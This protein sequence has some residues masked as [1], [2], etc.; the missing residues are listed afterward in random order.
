MKSFETMPIFSCHGHG[1]PW[2]THDISG[3]QIHE[4]MVYGSKKHSGTWGLF[5]VFVHR[6]MGEN[7]R[8]SLPSLEQFVGLQNSFHMQK[9]ST[10]QFPK[11][12]L[13]K[14]SNDH[15]AG[16]FQKVKL[17]FQHGFN[18]STSDTTGGFF[19][20]PGTLPQYRGVVL[21]LLWFCFIWKGGRRRGFAR[22]RHRESS[23]D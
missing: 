1:S 22:E 16:L 9:V 14:S 5:Q 3:H 18:S 8:L 23:R 21:P 20:G 17:I 15:L 13:W 2:I 7:Q 12:R 11:A 10:T 19:F 4:L 6:K